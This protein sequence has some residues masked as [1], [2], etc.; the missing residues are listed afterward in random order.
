MSMSTSEILAGG[1]RDL[2]RARI[3]GTK[4]PGAALPSMVEML[5]NGDCFQFAIANYIS[6]GGKPL[7]GVGV[8]PDVQIPLSR[9]ALLE[10]HDL[11][12]EA[13]ARWIQSLKVKPGL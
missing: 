12:V 8:V 9:A 13:A 11:A 10:G 3:F 2:K 6:A 1:L 4:T 5:P 7:E